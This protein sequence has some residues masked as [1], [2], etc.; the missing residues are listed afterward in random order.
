MNE[1]TLRKAYRDPAWPGEL[2]RVTP[3][4]PCV[5][6]GCMTYLPEG[7]ARALC[8][9]CER[10]AREVGSLAAYRERRGL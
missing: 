6:P 7:S 4:E 10:S 8:R 3:G 9:F 5:G 2:P 1:R